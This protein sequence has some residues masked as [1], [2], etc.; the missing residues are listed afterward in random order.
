MASGQQ[1]IR[2][3]APD[4]QVLDRIFVP[5]PLPLANLKGLPKVAQDAIS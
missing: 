5:H 1:L 4:Y 3:L 2:L